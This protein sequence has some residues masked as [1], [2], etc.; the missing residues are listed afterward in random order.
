MTKDEINLD[1]KKE[2]KN[3]LEKNE[4]KVTSQNSNSKNTSFSSNET[5]IE[6]INNFLYFTPISYEK[7][8]Y[9]PSTPRKMKEN[10]KNEELVVLGRNLLDLFESL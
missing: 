1:N 9:I 8:K 5:K 7:K 3:H 6:N 10:N 2:T 4:I